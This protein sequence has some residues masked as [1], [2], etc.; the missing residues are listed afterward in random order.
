M[1]FPHQE[2]KWNYTI[3]CSKIFESHQPGTKLEMCIL[4]T[5]A[6][7]IIEWHTW[8]ASSFI[9]IMLAKIFSENLI[10]KLLINL[11]KLDRS[12][13]QRE[14]HREI[15]Q[16]L[17]LRFNG[18][19]LLQS[20]KVK[21]LFPTFICKEEHLDCLF[22]TPSFTYDGFKWKLIIKYSA[23]INNSLSRYSGFIIHRCCCEI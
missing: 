16:T 22:I 14:N 9:V 7:F 1:K 13:E 12:S 11:R 6:V 8:S 5:H 17:I 20:V 15:G 4:R 18:F 21:G 19:I 23:H 3:Q 10:R 2:V